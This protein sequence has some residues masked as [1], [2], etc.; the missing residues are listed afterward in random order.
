MRKLHKG[1]RSIAPIGQVLVLL[2][3]IVCGGCDW[4]RSRFIPENLFGVWRTDDPRYRGRSIQLGKDNV[5]IGTGDDKPSIELVES[6]RIRPAGEDTTYSIHCR[7]TDGTQHLLTLSFNPNG[8]GEIRLSHPQNIVWKRRPD[9]DISPHRP[10]TD[11]SLSYHHVQLVP[12]PLY[13]I[14][15]VRRNCSRDLDPH[16]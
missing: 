12:R 3:P 16:R 8:D 5:V 10:T 1:V 11:L 4:N 6:V 14:D 7:T 15:C 9:T 2:L 13:E